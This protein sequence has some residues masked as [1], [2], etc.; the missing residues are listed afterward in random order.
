M[1][2]AKERAS[3]RVIADTEEEKER[4]GLGIMPVNSLSVSV[5]IQKIFNKYCL[6]SVVVV[7][8]NTRWRILQ[9]QYFM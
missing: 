6:Q 9:T 4:G 3:E 8:H 1:K 2:R 7:A 5:D